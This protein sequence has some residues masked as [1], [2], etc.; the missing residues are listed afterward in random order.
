MLYH[1]AD[2]RAN[3]GSWTRDLQ[4]LTP[5]KG[6]WRQGCCL[7][8]GAALF[9]GAMRSRKTDQSGMVGPVDDVDQ[10]PKSGAG[11][12]GR[13]SICLIVVFSTAE[14]KTGWLID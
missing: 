6:H 8:G 11:A 9:Y 14:I 10:L 1:L 7:F 2:T 12:R 5:S 3:P 13:Y 4:G